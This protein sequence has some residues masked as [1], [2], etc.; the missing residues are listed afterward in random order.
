MLEMFQTKQTTLYD[1][2][3]PS[4][5]YLKLL[6]YYGETWAKRMFGALVAKSKEWGRSVYYSDVFVFYTD[7]G[8]STYNILIDWSKV[9]IPEA[10]SYLWYDH[11]LDPN[12]EW[13]DKLSENVSRDDFYN[14]MGFTWSKEKPSF[15]NDFTFKRFPVGTSLPGV[16]MF[17]EGDTSLATGHFAL[18]KRY[19]IKTPEDILV[20]I[21]GGRDK[22]IHYWLLGGAL[23]I[24]SPTDN[25]LIY[26]GMPENNPLSTVLDNI[27][28]T[29]GGT[30]MMYPNA[31]EWHST[32]WQDLLVAF[33]GV[34][35]EVAGV[36]L[37]L[38]AGATIG[39]ILAP[40]AAKFAKGT[41]KPALGKLP[42]SLEM[43]FDF[44]F[45]TVS[46]YYKKK[47]SANEN[48]KVAQTLMDIGEVG[49]TDTVR[50]ASHAQ[51]LT[52]QMNEIMDKNDALTKVILENIALCVD[53]A[54]RDNIMGFDPRYQ[55]TGP[56]TPKTVYSAAESTA[57]FRQ[58]GQMKAIEKIGNVQQWVETSKTGP[59]GP[60]TRSNNLVLYAALGIG[61]LALYNSF[62]K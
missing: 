12:L 50:S 61:A 10:S 6:M 57:E 41:L 24:W 56:M 17:W 59:Q 39:Q 29:P 40:I 27:R 47:G 49:I 5:S 22:W 14:D 25:D 2:D 3:D 13:I 34:A 28:T 55:K 54:F 20:D 43:S 19:E 48:L 15:G 16:R 37:S 11:F 21:F 58:A 42:L 26:T 45:A 8:V 52:E 46:N 38:H 51:Q 9:G 18:S 30:D 31:L 1:V 7:T 44:A 60:E 23:P 36:I 62:K 35:A 4:T 53:P 33:V 32:F